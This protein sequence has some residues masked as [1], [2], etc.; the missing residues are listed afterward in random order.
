MTNDETYELFEVQYSGRDYLCIPPIPRPRET[1]TVP[2][3]PR[4]VFDG[5][6]PRASAQLATVVWEA[7]PGTM[8]ALVQQTD[9]TADKVYTVLA[10]F[11]RE[12]KLRTEKVPLSCVIYHR[13]SEGES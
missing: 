10:R 11:R 13:A 1:P 3:D 12:G 2:R 5:D 8:A 9:L 4:S 7:L 6:R